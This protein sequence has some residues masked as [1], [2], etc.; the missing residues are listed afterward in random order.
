MSIC[1]SECEDNAPMLVKWSV[2]NCNDFNLK[3]KKCAQFYQIPQQ[4]LSINKVGSLLRERNFIFKRKSNNY[5]MATKKYFLLQNV[6]GDKLNTKLYI[7][8]NH[9]FTDYT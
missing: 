9:L 7:Y 8:S 2:K 6:K 1:E 4:K 5:R 3:Y